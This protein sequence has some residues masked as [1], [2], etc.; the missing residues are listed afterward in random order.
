ML[1]RGCVVYIWEYI[2]WCRELKSKWKLLERGLDLGNM[3]GG[4]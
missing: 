3:Q 2:A 1:L 4:V